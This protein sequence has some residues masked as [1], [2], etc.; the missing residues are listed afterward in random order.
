MQIKTTNGYSLTLTRM[1]TDK[2]KNI[3]SV[4]EDRATLGS[5]CAADKSIK[6]HKP[7]INVYVHVRMHVCMSV[8]MCVSMDTTVFA[9]NLQ[10]ILP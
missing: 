5:L 6:Q 3:W 10:I 7:Y 4:D 1:V 2:S 8:C 9:Y